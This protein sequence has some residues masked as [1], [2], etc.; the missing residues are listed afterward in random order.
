VRYL[1]WDG[2][3]LTAQIA[4]HEKKVCVNGDEISVCGIAEV[5]VAS[6]Y[7]GHGL[8]KLMLNA[9]HNDRKHNGDQ[10]SLLFGDKEIYASSGY[11][12]VDNVL[13]LNEDKTWVKADN[14][15]VRPL[16][17]DW[18]TYEVKLIGLAF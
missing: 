11:V 16:N 17:Q 4:V 7:R 3:I 13:L 9:I 8:A 2:D 5:C 6:N 18:P 12:C 1:V 10:F 15:M 14:V